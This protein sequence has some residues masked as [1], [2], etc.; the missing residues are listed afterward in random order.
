[1]EISQAAHKAQQR[2]TPVR[3]EYVMPQRALVQEVI[4]RISEG[5]SD[6]DLTAFICATYR[7]VLLTVAETA[8]LNRLNR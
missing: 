2:G 7:L 5:V 1:M 3:I 8:A 6:K 4:R